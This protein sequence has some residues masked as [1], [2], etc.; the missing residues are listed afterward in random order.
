MRIDALL[1]SV[2]L[3][4]SAQALPGE[5]SGGEVQR[6]SFARAVAQRPQILLADEPTASLDSQTAHDLLR[7]MLD[8]VREER[9]T[10]IVTTHDP[11][12]IELADRT[13]HMRDGKMVDQASAIAL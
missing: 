7:L 3:A 11:V 13:M 5:L 9:A 12:V 2:D 8:V 10:L 1:Q 6:I 4:D